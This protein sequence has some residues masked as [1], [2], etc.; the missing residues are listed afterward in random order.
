MTT[1]D[2]GS[3]LAIVLTAALASI[4]VA[5]LA[6]RLV[7]PV[8]VLEL[9]LG[10]VIGPQGLGLANVDDFTEFL[11]NLGL[12]MLFF[13]AGYELDLQRVRAARSSWAP[14][15]ER[16]SL[17]IADGI[18]GILGAAGVVLSLIYTGSAMATTAIG[19]L[20]PILSDAGELRTRFGTYPWASGPSES[21][22]RS[23]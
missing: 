19:T 14:S 23:C 8:V 13:F 16:S 3:F 5:F 2:A 18:G 21:S 7:L 17:A 11:G 12:G 20:I 1:V 9:V 10:I 15:H 4:L 6:P 22:A